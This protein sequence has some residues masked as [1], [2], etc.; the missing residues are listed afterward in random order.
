MTL[1]ASP[2]TPSVRQVLVHG[3]LR[4]ALTGRVP[5]DTTISVHWEQGAKGGALDLTLVMKP[6]GFFAFHGDPVLDLPDFSGG[7][8][9]TLR[10]CLERADCPPVEAPLN[11][12][13]AQLVPVNTALT[14]DGLSVSVF[15]VP[16]APFEISPLVPPRP[17]ALEG[18][19]IRDF[20]PDVPAA[21][22]KV[23]VPGALPATSDGNGWFYIPTVPPGETV[24]ATFTDG[25]ADPADHTF[26]PDL[27]DAKTTLTLS[28]PLARS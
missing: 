25:D 3:R 22:V 16:G 4:E 27:A 5:T 19:L 10:I 24:T 12:P 18:Y 15:K 9:V 28:L 7:G 11:V 21:G 23:S 8:D 6:G 1:I 2:G 13:E 14:I 17:F 26:Q 20:D